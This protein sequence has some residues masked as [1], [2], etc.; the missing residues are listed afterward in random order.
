MAKFYPI[1]IKEK[2]FSIRVFEPY[3]GAKILIA[4]QGIL[5]NPMLGGLSAKTLDMESGE[6]VFGAI[7]RLSDKIDEKTMDRLMGMLLDPNYISVDLNDDNQWVKMEE[8]VFNQTELGP[9][10]LFELMGH[11]VKANYEDFGQRVLTLFGLVR[12]KFPG[13]FRDSSA[14]APK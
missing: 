6:A 4:L 7:Q 10:E 2:K 1:T 9:L 13:A 3:K 11:V 8:R 14:L 12:E 5:I